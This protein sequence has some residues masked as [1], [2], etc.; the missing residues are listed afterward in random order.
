MLVQHARFIKL[1]QC[2]LFR[3]MAIKLM[4]DS[5]DNQCP[6]CAYEGNKKFFKPRWLDRLIELVARNPGLGVEPDLDNMNIH[7]LYGL[8]VWLSGYADHGRS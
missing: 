5:I 7:E 4:V 6:V 8:Y 1:A 3:V 2:P